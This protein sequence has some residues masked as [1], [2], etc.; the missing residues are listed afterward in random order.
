M[1]QAAVLAA[2]GV[3]IA[4]SHQPVQAAGGASFYAAPERTSYQVG[5][6][7]RVAVLINSAGQAVNAGEATVTWSP[8]L[9]YSFV[10]TASSIFT[11]WTSGGG[12]GPVGSA[13]SVYFS[14][15]LSN[16]GYNGTAGR[17]VTVI[18]NAT[19]PG[20]FN[21]NIAGSQILAN[22]GM[23]T[24]ILCCS[25][26]TSFTV[27]AKAP[28]QPLISVFS[29]THPNQS[30]W[31][32]T[33]IVNLN[34]YATTAIGNYSYKFDKSPTGNPTAPNNATIQ[35]SQS[36]NDGLW[37]FHL[38]GAN[39]SGSAT[40]HFAIRI[41]STAP[42]AFTVTPDATNDP[43]NPSPKFNFSATDTTS[44]I[45]HY[46]AS[47]DGGAAF[48]LASGGAIPK[49]KPGEH[50]IA[51]TAHDRAGNTTE[52]SAK[53]K[54]SGIKP[55]AILGG[56]ISL[57]VNKPMKFVGQSSATDTIHVYLNGKQIE[58]FV[59]RT[60]QVAKTKSKGGGGFP[61]GITW[62][63]TYHPEPIPDTYKIYFSR[64]T[65]LGA[66]SEPSKERSVTITATAAQKPEKKPFV[67]DTG[68]LIL[69]LIILLIILDVIF[70]TAWRYYAHLLHRTKGRP[71]PDPLHE[72][73]K[74]VATWRP[75]GW[76]IRGT[77][78]AERG[79]I[80]L[81]PAKHTLPNSNKH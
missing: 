58:E 6:V 24:N 79:F 72:A 73:L 74:A 81:G 43:S 9:Q 33:H 39:A 59:A 69:L 23:G 53:F 40:I 27:G 34:W 28:P 75:F 68:L 42:T 19:Q 20:T 45:A 70:F 11:T 66:E 22:D 52:A 7:V 65:T 51:V 76:L 80:Q 60:K 10:S 5:D 67:V 1:L 41:D 61:D 15:G 78:K 36:L 31:Y 26:G 47:I 77:I 54:I 3:L 55:P 29:K 64:T 4:A 12:A 37:Y 50:V 49:Q 18:F 30:Q 46:T 57:V 35:T 16:P 13:G 63:Y 32:K 21:V 25:T 62:E 8:G 56:P 2:S 71:V 44:G 17:V 14:G 38:K 48:P